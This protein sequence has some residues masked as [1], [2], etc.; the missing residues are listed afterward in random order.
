MDELP[1]KLHGDI[2]VKILKRVLACEYFSGFFFFF[3]STCFI[4]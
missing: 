1:L 3:S 2:K 4:L